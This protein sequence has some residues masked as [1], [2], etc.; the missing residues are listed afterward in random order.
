[1]KKLME[2]QDY[3]WK[4]FLGLLSLY[5]IYSVILSFIFQN[6]NSFPS[7]YVRTQIIVS[8]YCYG[9]FQFFKIKSDSKKNPKTRLLNFSS[10]FFNLF[11][12]PFTLMDLLISVLIYLNPAT[13]ITDYM[14]NYLFVYPV[15][16]IIDAILILFFY[17][18]HKNA[19]KIPPQKELEIKTEAV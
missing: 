3:L 12:I 10:Y 17:Y 4:A 5:V 9:K 16:F 18:I 7:V 11:V 19:T 13:V 2:I 8:L 1:M 14:Q 15:L 6:A